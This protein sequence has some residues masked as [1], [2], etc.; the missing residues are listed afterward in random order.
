MAARQNYKI[1]GIISKIGQ[2]ESKS[3]S[4]TA[5]Q[6]ILDVEDGN[7]TQNIPIQFTQDRCD[8]CDNFSEGE[9]VTISFNLRGRI[10]QDKCFGSIEGWKIEGTGNVKP[11]PQEAEPVA[12]IVDEP[13]TDSLP[14]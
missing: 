12:A 13:P 4:F 6:V 5:R 14:F 3:N 10:W 1:T 2:R 9:E 8:L 11:K 7:Y